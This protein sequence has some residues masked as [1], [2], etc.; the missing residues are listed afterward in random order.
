MPAFLFESSEQQVRAVS[1]INSLIISSSILPVYLL[2]KGLLKDERI[3]RIIVIVT[4]V[5]PLMVFSVYFMSEVLFLPISLW[6]MFLVWKLL[7]NK[8]NKVLLSVLAGILF[9]LSYLNKE[10]SLYF[11]I[12][13]LMVRIL[14]LYL[15]RSEL[16]V[17][18]KSLSIVLIS[19]LA[20]F[21]LMKLTLFRGMGNSYSQMGIEAILTK[22]RVLYLIYGFIYNSLFAILSFGIFPVLIP[23]STIEREYKK[24]DQFCLFLLLSFL[25]GCVA[26]AYTITV[27]EDFLSRSPRQHTRYL[28]PLVMPFIVMMIYKIREKGCLKKR[29]SLFVWLLI[30]YLAAFIVFAYGINSGSCHVDHP[31]LEF[32]DILFKLQEKNILPLGY[33][34]IVW[35]YKFCIIVVVSICTFLLIRHN[36]YFLKTFLILFILL[37]LINYAWAY[38]IAV[39]NYKITK[40]ESHALSITNDFLSELDGTILLFSGTGFKEE[41]QWFDTY[42]NRELYYTD[43]HVLNQMGYLDDRVIDLETERIIAEWPT[44]P[45]ESLNQVDY[46]IIKEGGSDWQ[47]LLDKGMMFNNMEIMDE[48][49]LPGYILYKNLNP[50]KMELRVN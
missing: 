20:C 21:F 22:E 37:S 10:I 19:F 24:E 18:I 44:K 4:M 26:I 46:I 2:A 49:P 30:L 41:N 47:M 36:E 42:M 50:E 3:V 33:A 48:F 27:R 12:A 45:Y 43:L 32:Y 31:G 38:Q 23:L 8:V 35:L 25:I 16:E 15:N 14:Y 9:Y 7:D 11:L 39:R 34:Q 5:S 13:Y 6:L 1:W 17:E 40:E 29:I 28:I